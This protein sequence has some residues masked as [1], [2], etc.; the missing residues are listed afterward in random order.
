MAAEGV[1]MEGVPGAV[2]MEGVP[3]A[4]GNGA[5]FGLPSAPQVKEIISAIGKFQ[6]HSREAMMTLGQDNFQGGKVDIQKPHSQMFMTTHSLQLLPAAIQ[7]T[8]GAK[9]DYTF[10]AQFFDGHLLMASQFKNGTDTTGRLRYEFTKRFAATL[11]GQVGVA[12]AKVDG[13]LDF[14]RLDLDYKG[15][16]FISSLDMHRV[17]QTVKLEMDPRIGPVYTALIDKKTGR[18]ESQKMYEATFTHNQEITEALCVG[19]SLTRKQDK[20]GSGGWKDGKL[21]GS[22]GFRYNANEWIATGSVM[23]ER[24][25][26]KGFKESM[27]E[28]RDS[29]TMNVTYAHK[30][31]DKPGMNTIWL[32]TEYELEPDLANFRDADSWDAN[33]RASIGYLIDLRQSTLKAQVD[34]TGRVRG[35]FEERLNNM[36]SLVLSCDLDHFHINPA[37]GDL[38][39]DYRFGF[40]V[41]VGG[42][43]M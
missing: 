22:L 28:V 29:A 16:N 4:A 21:S 1:S 39:P 33:S 41:T 7:A 43:M 23:G 38:M 30:V 17:R 36:A 26:G 32:A 24:S 35:T 13:G 5:M 25:D 11:M 2:S 19:G 42:G 27:T 6:E 3:G 15:S 40:G 34:T 8:T 9:S 14:F 31:V 20:D 12:D 18:D 37:K 10:G